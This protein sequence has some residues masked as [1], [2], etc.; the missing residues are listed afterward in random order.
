M[1]RS[2][3]LLASL[4]FASTFVTATGG[5]GTDDDDIWMPPSATGKADGV[6]ILKGS[7]IPSQFVSMNKHY[8][9]G[10]TISTLEQIAALVDMPDSVAK[11]ADGIIA[12]LPANGRL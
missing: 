11:R 1:F 9:T 5:C 2:R 10:R 3:F 12:N 6:Q 8:L 7:D 4:L